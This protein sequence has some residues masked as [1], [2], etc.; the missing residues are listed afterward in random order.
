MTDVQ[1]VRLLIGDNDPT[2]YVYQDDELQGYLDIRDGSLR[3][4]AAD[5]LNA[6]ANKLARSASKEVVGDYSLDNTLAPQML[7]QQ[8]EVLVT[9]ENQTP[10]FG[11]A[12]LNLGPMSETGIIASLLQRTGGL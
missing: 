12:E 10:A 2:A 1:N 5:A 11:V 9:L 3:L 4:A 6:L 8:A 7:R